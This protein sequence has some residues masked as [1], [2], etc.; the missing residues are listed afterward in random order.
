MQTCLFEGPIVH[1]M[2][3]A[4]SSY[5]IDE[6]LAHITAIEA[7]LGMGLDHDT[8]HRPRIK[9]ANPGATVR[10]GMRLASLLNDEACRD[11]FR[12][13][14]KARSEF[15]HGRCMSRIASADRLL[16]RRLARKMASQ[17]VAL[18]IKATIPSRNDFLQQLLEEKRS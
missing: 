14:F 3:R 8:R 7:G 17:L 13:L 4:Y 11:Q 1:F 15:L 2:N 9:G 16:A 10:I 12:H 6:F 5:G 18:S